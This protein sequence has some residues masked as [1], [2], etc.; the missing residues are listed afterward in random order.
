MHSFLLFYPCFYFPLL[1]QSYS[2]FLLDD[3]DYCIE[4][5]NLELSDRLDLFV[6]ICFHNAYDFIIK[7]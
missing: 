2:W 6:K 1:V 3:L 7:F 4:V 5:K